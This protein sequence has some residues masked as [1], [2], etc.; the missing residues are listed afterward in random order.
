VTQTGRLLLSKTAVSQLGERLWEDY[1]AFATHDLSEYEITY[2]FVDG[3]AERLRPGSKREPVV[4]AWGLYGG[5]SSRAVAH[6]GRLQGRCRDGDRLLRGYE[7]ALEDP[8]DS[9]SH[10][11]AAHVAFE[12]MKTLGPC[13]V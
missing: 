6:D 9:T 11:G 8:G 1:Q 7:A 10:N 3:I 5:G 12:R 13:D 4:A 2:L